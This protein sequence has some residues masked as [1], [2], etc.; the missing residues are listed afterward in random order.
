MLGHPVQRPRHLILR[1]ATQHRRRRQVLVPARE[2]LCGDHAGA[3]VLVGLPL[4][5]QG[6]RRRPHRSDVLAIRPVRLLGP[7]QQPQRPGQQVAAL[8]FG[9]QADGPAR[10]RGHGVG[11]RRCSFGQR[12]ARRRRGVRFLLPLLLLRHDHLRIAVKALLQPRD[13]H[14]LQRLVERLGVVAL[15]LQRLPGHLV[16]DPLPELAQVL[17]RLGEDRQRI[18]REL[19]QVARL[20]LQLHVHRR[21]EV[22]DDL[23]QEAHA[24]VAAP[25]EHQLHAL[26]HLLELLARALLRIGL[27]AADVALALGVER[28]GG[29]AALEVRRRALHEALHVLHQ[30]QKVAAGLVDQQFDLLGLQAGQLVAHPRGEV[31]ARRQQQLD[32]VDPQLAAE[33]GER[34]GARVVGQ[35]RVLVPVGLP[36]RRDHQQRPALLGR[37]RPQPADEVERLGVDP[38]H[39]VAQQDERQ[40]AADG[41]PLHQIDQLVGERLAGRVLAVAAAALPFAMQV[42]RLLAELEHAGQPGRQHH[43]LGEVGDDRQRRAAEF[44]GAGDPRRQVAQRVGVLDD[45]AD[46]AGVAVVAG[47]AQAPPHEL[48]RRRRW[49]HVRIDAQ[50]VLVAAEVVRPEVA[51]VPRRV[52]GEPAVQFLRETRLADARVREDH[53]HARPADAAALAVALSDLFEQLLE[54]REFLFATE[55]AGGHGTGGEDAKRCQGVGRS[56]DARPP[57]IPRAIRRCHPATWPKVKGVHHATPACPGFFQRWRVRREGPCSRP[58]RPRKRGQPRPASPADAAPAPHRGLPLARI[59]VAERVEV[60]PA[61]ELERLLAAV[62][63]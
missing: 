45:R 26:R 35:A 11:V 63:A 60:V 5:R 44:L 43:V 17:G 33:A 6:Q 50:A 13:Q 25:A 36:V 48:R 57:T 40:L 2:S 53:R 61:R 39:V 58:R 49:R 38:L 62:P 46:V 27:E 18:R 21:G 23:A 54:T 15:D 19:D 28:V 32:D 51:V 4:Q 37:A 20:L 12:L 8:F 3:V 30:L 22:A 55:E 16:E 47:G 56:E 52:R 42:A 41:Q 7:R 29:T 34:R 59:A 1:E 24:E 10:G 14:P 31:L 9:Q